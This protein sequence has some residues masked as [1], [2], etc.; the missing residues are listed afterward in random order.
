MSNNNLM[1]LGIGKRIY[2]RRRE[3]SMTQEKLSELSDTTPQAIS[4]YER[5][6]RELKAG[7]IIKIA[8][9]LNVSTDYLLIGNSAALSGAVESELSHLNE[10]DALVI[11][12][13]IRKCIKLAKK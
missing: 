8:D 1:L 4:N 9:A 3:L 11:N 12:D 10:N 6:E 7:T 13:I 5:G 2:E